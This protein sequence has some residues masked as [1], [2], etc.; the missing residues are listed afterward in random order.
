MFS[1]SLFHFPFIVTFVFGA[2]SDVTF[3]INC[4]PYLLNLDLKEAVDFQRVSATVSD[5]GIEFV[6][7]KVLINAASLHV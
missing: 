1:V 4:Q 3:K 5:S 2:V 7:P 6:I